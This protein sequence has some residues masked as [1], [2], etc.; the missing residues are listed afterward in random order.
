MLPF[1]LRGARIRLVTLGV[2]VDHVADRGQV[3]PLARDP[4]GDVSLL[5]LAEGLGEREL[6]VVAHRLIAEEQHRVLVDRGV[7]RVDEVGGERAG[8][9]H[10]LNSSAEVVVEGV[11]LH[12][13]SLVRSLGTRP[14]SAC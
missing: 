5:R 8:Q 3:D 4:V 9:V 12:P 11:E 10:A 13:T 14:R 2:T 6:S 7:E 1:W